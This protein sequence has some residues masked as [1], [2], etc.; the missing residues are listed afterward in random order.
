[1]S[2]ARTCKRAVDL[3]VAAAALVVLAPLLLAVAAWLRLV[4]RH[5][6]L[7]T[8]VRLGRRGRPF[9]I[10]K[11]RTMHAGSP[12]E[13]SVAPADDPRVTN[14]GR[15]LRRWRLDEL[16]QLYDVLVGSMSLVGPRPQTS[17][18]LEAV[19]A[20]SRERLQ[21]VRP[22]ITGPAAVECLGE[23]EALAGLPDPVHAYRTV[24]VP[25]KVRLELD[26]LQQWSLRRDARIAA[27]TLARVFS[28]RA[29]LRSATRI[30]GWIEA[31]AD[32]PRP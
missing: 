22:G 4:E 3:L 21:R 20:R 30:R 8:E 19:D 32:G 6:V 17:A 25:A 7:H 31:A 18:N 15:F 10:H 26:Y 28:R 5:P 12:C 1:M 2:G 24:V 16:P 23:D 14:T 27:A 11:F 9:R 13:P 29:R